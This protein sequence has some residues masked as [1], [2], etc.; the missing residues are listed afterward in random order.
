MRHSICVAAAL[1]RSSTGLSLSVD[2]A[3]AG[4]IAAIDPAPSLGDAY[5]LVAFEA[6]AGEVPHFYLDSH[7]FSSG[8]L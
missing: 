7:P 3:P 5:V 6:F 4:W 1:P 2:R 8:S